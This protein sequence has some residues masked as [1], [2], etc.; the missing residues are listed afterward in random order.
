MGWREHVSKTGFLTVAAFE[1]L[2]VFR[3]EMVTLRP[4]IRRER[5]PQALRAC[6]LPFRP[7]R[8]LLRRLISRQLQRRYLRQL[9]RQHFPSP[10]FRR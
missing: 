7:D 4:D 2:F 9:T 10:R 8:R 1:R 3:F 6:A 5:H